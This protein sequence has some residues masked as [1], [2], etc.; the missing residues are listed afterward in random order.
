MCVHSASSYIILTLGW[1]R[2]TETW[3]FVLTDGQHRILAI[4]K[5][6]EAERKELMLNFVPCMFYPIVLSYDELKAW[7]FGENA[8]AAFAV[9][10]SVFTKLNFIMEEYN[11]LP[12]ASKE[13]GA[14]AAL[15]SMFEKKDIPSMSRQHIGLFFENSCP[16]RTRNVQ[17][18]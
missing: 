6:D 2:E 5:F 12:E 4:H 17:I 13:R 9:K 18:Y 7:S 8:A 14:Q 10:V 16:V 3:L 15:T 1:D 11:K